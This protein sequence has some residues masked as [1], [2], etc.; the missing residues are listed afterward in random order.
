MLLQNQPEKIRRQ[1]EVRRL[2]GG[3][4]GE[5]LRLAPREPLAGITAIEFT[6]APDGRIQ[7]LVIEDQTGNLNQFIF[8]NFQDRRCDPEWFNLGQLDGYSWFNLE[9]EPRS[10]PC[11]GGR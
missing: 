8:S 10:S 1:F 6:I 4:D 9:C 7:G 2:P 11:D 5:K 3:K